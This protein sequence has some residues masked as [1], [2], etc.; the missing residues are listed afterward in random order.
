MPSPGYG[1]ISTSVIW[2]ER[3]TSGSGA[4][5]G[6][7]RVINRRVIRAQRAAGTRRVARTSPSPGQHHPHHTP[8]RGALGGL[9]SVAGAG[10]GHGHYTKPLGSLGLWGAVGWAGWAPQGGCRR[11]GPCSAPV[12]AGAGNSGYR[13]IGRGREGAAPAMHHPRCRRLQLTLHNE[14]T[15]LPAGG[16]IPSLC[17]PPCR[18]LAP[19]PGQGSGQGAGEGGGPCGPAAW[20]KMAAGS[21]ELGGVLVIGAGR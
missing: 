14:P 9:P 10:F 3:L 19:I 8:L 13:S 21:R 17:P 6:H 20:G 1:R 2:G 11:T 12:F 7:G 18:H 16:G 5:G 4:S 15:P